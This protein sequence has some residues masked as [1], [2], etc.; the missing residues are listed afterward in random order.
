MDAK[1]LNITEISQNMAIY[2]ENYLGKFKLSDGES[3]F[4]ENYLLHFDEVK[5][6][7]PEQYHHLFNDG[8]KFNG[9][10]GFIKVGTQ[11]HCVMMLADENYGKIY[12]LCLQETDAN[13]QVRLIVI[14]DFLA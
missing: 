10:S 8:S 2:V 4:Q 5:D 11:E 1:S 3:L 12:L 6:F 9:A 13:G 7:I 14:K